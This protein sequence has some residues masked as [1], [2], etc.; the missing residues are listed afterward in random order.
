MNQSNLPIILHAI[1]GLAVVG[2]LSA[3]GA[4]HVISGDQALTGISSVVAFLLGT[5]STLLG[6]SSATTTAAVTPGP[7]VPVVTGHAVPVQQVP[8]LAV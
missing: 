6:A 8:P 3:L 5:G 7:T 2:A 1:I 4:V